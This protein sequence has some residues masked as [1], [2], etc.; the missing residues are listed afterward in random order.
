MTAEALGHVLVR[1]PDLTVRRRWLFQAVMGKM[2][3]CPG[4]RLE[5]VRGG[6][7][8]RMMIELGEDR[9]RSDVLK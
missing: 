4:R 6:R 2:F 3:E 1:W 8:G 5:D 7:G 9:Q